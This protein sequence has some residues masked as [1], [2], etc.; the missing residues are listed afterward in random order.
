MIDA[1]DGCQMAASCFRTYCKKYL[2]LFVLLSYVL[3]L[4]DGLPSVC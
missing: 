4:V 2:D 3:V 1:D